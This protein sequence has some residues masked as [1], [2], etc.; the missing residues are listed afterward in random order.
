MKV[1][2]ANWHYGNIKAPLGLLCL[3]LRGSELH[4]H[5]K[6]MLTATVFTARA[7]NLLC[8]PV[9][10]LDYTLPQLL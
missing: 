3:L 1:C 7:H 2:I 5:L 8:A 10:S 9:C 6:V 4:G